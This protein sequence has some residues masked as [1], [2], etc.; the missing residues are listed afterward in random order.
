M[1]TH[2]HLCAE[3]QY[4]SN[5]RVLPKIIYVTVGTVAVGTRR[6]ID[7]AGSLHR[8]VS[9]SLCPSLA[10][11]IPT[12]YIT[13]FIW[14]LTIWVSYAP[15]IDVAQTSG[16]SQRAKD[17]TNLIGRLCFSLFLCAALL[18]FEKFSI[19]WIAG[20]FHEKSYAGAPHFLYC[21][22]VLMNFFL[23]CRAY[24]ATKNCRSRSCDTL[25]PL[26]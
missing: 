5:R 10:S 4:S 24:S 22:L 25:P 16:A 23:K 20:K 11:P 7:W 14:T 18:L 2:I 21:R 1:Y 26:S 19:Q 12:S 15:L 6:Y 8:F 17:A 13:L 9:T 3:S